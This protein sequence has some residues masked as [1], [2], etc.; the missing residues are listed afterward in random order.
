MDL[1]RNKIVKFYEKYIVV[2]GLSGH[3]MFL[4]QASEIFLAKSSNNVSLNGFL[5]ACLSLIS[6]LIYGLIKND[7]PLIIV[8]I[9]GVA[10]SLTC[11]M[12]I[13]WFR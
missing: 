5:V 7:R 3:L 13:L 2:I 10:A 4:L 8:N 12:F 1:D 9:F 11:I 6:W